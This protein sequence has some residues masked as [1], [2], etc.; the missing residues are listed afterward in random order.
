MIFWFSGTGNSKYAAQRMAEA[1]NEPLLC[2]ND[3]IK[4]HDTAAVET[5]ERLV[6]VTPT[7][8]WRI[9][10]LVRDWLLQTELRG[11]RQAWFVMTC[12]SEIGSADRYNRE[13]CRAKGLSCMGTAQIVMPENYIAMFGVPQAGSGKVEVTLLDIL[14]LL[15]SKSYWLLLAGVL[16]GACVFLVTTF[17][18]TPTYESRVS[19]YVYNSSNNSVQS[20]T[21]NNGDLQAAESLATTYSKILASNSIL[22]AVLQEL[23]PDVSLSRK[24]L[25]GMVS[26]SVITDTQLLE[27]VI[28]ST[29]PAF[30]CRVAGAFAKV[31]P[32]EIVRITK[33]G[34]VEIVDQ[35]EIPT[36]KASPRTVFDAAIGVIIGVMVAAVI[37]ILR[38]LADTTI[39]LPEDIENMVGIT[40]LGQIP[41]INSADDNYAYWTVTEEGAAKNEKE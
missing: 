39:Y 8:A 2:M 7:Y 1:L 21:I 31:A 37:V 29:D 15:L 14:K 32:T 38:T 9:P 36:D 17:L 11:A 40:V 23:G 27:V 35:P 18:I 34:G 24:S 22:D 4:A 20:G 6:I 3:R 5:G 19:F 33:A 12:G 16:A 26:V 13:L 25:S 10:R 30:A 41:D 28:T